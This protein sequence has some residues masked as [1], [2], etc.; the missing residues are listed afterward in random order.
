M[1]AAVFAALV[2]LAPPHTALAAQCPAGVK[3]VTAAVP[4]GKSGQFRTDQ[5]CTIRVRPGLTAAKR[6]R[7]TAHEMEHARR[8]AVRP[9]D[10][11]FWS[12]GEPV[13]WS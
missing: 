4:A 3:V 6:A 13:V 12:M 8:F 7:V 11:E 5:P 9:A 2:I 10:V 1:I